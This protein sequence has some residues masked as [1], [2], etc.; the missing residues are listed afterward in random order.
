MPFLIAAT[1]LCA[2]LYLLLARPHALWLLIGAELL[3]NAPAPLLL[4][5]GTPEAVAGIF[6]LLFFALLEAGAAI[7]LF[8]HWHHPA[9]KLS[10]DS[11]WAE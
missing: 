1:F 7:F 4:V 10:L 9:G 5:A 11:L 6:V 2:G 8:F 3:L